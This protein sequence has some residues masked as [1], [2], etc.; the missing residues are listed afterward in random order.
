MSEQKPGFIRRLLHSV[1]QGFRFIRNF[2][3][4]FV[5]VLLFIGFIAVLFSDKEQVEVNEKTALVLNL[6]GDLV[7]EKQWG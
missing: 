6:K 2:V 7:E 4:N 5:F 3:L 1:W